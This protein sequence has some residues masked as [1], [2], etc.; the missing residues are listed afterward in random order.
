MILKT[1]KNSI[2]SVTLAC[3]A[4]DTIYDKFDWNLFKPIRNFCVVLDDD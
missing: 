1:I 2:L 3:V 4:S